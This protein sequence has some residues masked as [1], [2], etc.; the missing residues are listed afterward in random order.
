MSNEKK[1]YE[2][3]SGFFL[4]WKFGNPVFLDARIHMRGLVGS[5]TRSNGSA[6]LLIT[7]VVILD[8]NLEHVEHALR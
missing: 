7:M 6:R 4:L 2:D 5:E 1:F 3:L 8:G